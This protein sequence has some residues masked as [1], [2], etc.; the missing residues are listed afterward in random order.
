MYNYIA[1]LVFLTALIAM[2]LYAQKNIEGVWRTIDDETN[3]PKS[4]IQIYKTQS[5]KYAGKVVRILEKG[6]EDARC[7]KCTDWRKDQPV[8]GMII[9]LNLVEDGKEYTNGDILDPEK[10]KVYRCKMWLEDENTLKVRGYLG[11]FYRTQT[12]YRVQ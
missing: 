8:M 3:K 11:P 7:D 5:G 10:G 6:K 12:W 9:L 1:P 2:P 4:H